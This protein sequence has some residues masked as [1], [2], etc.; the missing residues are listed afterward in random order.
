MAESR[1][2]RVRCEPDQIQRHPRVPRGAPGHSRARRHHLRACARGQV[3]L[4]TYRRR[5][6]ADVDATG[7]VLVVMV[8]EQVQEMQLA[9]WIPTTEVGIPLPGWM[10]PGSPRSPTSQASS[11]RGSLAASSS[12]LTWWSSAKS[13]PSQGGTIHERL[14]DILYRPRQKLRVGRGI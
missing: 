12:A 11:P 1:D 9:G 5:F 4:A 10:G 6:G 14:R 3:L 13:T 8:G 2:W 7:V